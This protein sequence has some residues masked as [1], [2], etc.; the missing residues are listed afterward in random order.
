MLDDWRHGFDILLDIGKIEL[1]PGNRHSCA[2]AIAYEWL[3]AGGTRVAAS[4]L[5]QGGFAPLEGLLMA[6]RLS[7]SAVPAAVFHRLARLKLAY[8]QATGQRIPSHKPILGDAIFLVESGVHVDGINKNSA[9]Y[10]PFPPELIGMRRGISVGKHS[11]G[12]AIAMKLEQYGIPT[13]SRVVAELLAS[14]R[15]ESVRLGRGLSDEEFLEL[16]K[17]NQEQRW[18]PDDSHR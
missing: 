18:A 5:G 17:K 15:G 12:R 8:C 6:L 14:V 3:K 9:N 4:F 11:G 2:A 16:A 1:S 10:E 7:G 13:D